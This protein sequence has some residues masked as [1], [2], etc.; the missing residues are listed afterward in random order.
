MTQAND[1][2]DP[3]M[4]EYIAATEAQDEARFGRA[5]ATWTADLAGEAQPLPATATLS[6][7]ADREY[8]SRTGRESTGTAGRAAV[9]RWSEL[10]DEYRAACDYHAECG[11]E[12][13]CGCDD[14]ES[15]S[16]LADG[17]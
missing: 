6:M 14:C 5:Y 13:R 8:S 9:E 10:V 15:R 16:A 12:H 11:H 7:D 2:L 17:Q 4:R 3:I 1:D